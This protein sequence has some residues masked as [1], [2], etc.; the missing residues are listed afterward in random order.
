MAGNSLT[1]KRKK[2]SL[3]QFHQ[4]SSSLSVHPGWGETSSTALCPG[5]ASKVKPF[6]WGEENLDINCQ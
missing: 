6:I 4:V 5:E 3:T 2:D 1:M